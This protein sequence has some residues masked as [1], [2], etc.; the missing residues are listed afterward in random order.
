VTESPE[1]RVLGPLEVVLDGI[2]TRLAS[3]TQRT[4][5]A[6]L[7]AHPNEVVPTDR[8]AEVVWRG[9]PSDARRK[10]WFHVSKLRSTLRSAGAVLIT[11]PTGYML[12]IRPEQ[13]DAAQF[14]TLVRSA[15]S[16][17]SEDSAGAASTLRQA[18]VLWR[19]E[20]FED[21][22]H[23]DAVEPEVARL[24][25][26]RLTAVEDRLEADLALGRGSDVVPELEALVAEHPFREHFCAQLMIAL[27]RAGRQA[28]ALEAYRAARQKLVDELGLE[29]SEEL[30]KLE[31]RILA[32]DQTLAATL[33]EPRAS[34]V[35]AAQEERKLVTVLVAE[36]GL[37]GEIGEQRDPEDL[38]TF[39]SPYQA[40]VRS[41]IERYGGRV[42]TLVGNTVVA[43]FGS[44][45]A[46]DEDPERAVR[47]A[48]AVHQWVGE[49]DSTRRCRVA[50]ATGEALV[51][52]SVRA[53]EAEPTTV[54]DVVNAAIHLHGAAAAE[55]VFVG[56]QTFRASRH[57]IEYDE[58]EPLAEEA[59][60]PIRVWR[61]IRALAQPDI[62]LSQHQSP[63][64]GREHELAVLRERLAT[65]VAERSVQLVTILGVPGIGKSRLVAE[66]QRAAPAAGDTIKWRHGRSLPYED[67]VSF[68]ALGEVVKSESGI[69]ASDPTEAAKRKLDRAVERIVDDP[70]EAGRIATS[71]RALVGVGDA[72]AAVPRDE[73]FAAWRDFIEALAE[74]R[75]LVLVFEDLHW[76]DEGLLDFVDELVGRLRGVPLVVIATA[77]L[78]L[79]TRRPDWGGG[80]PASPTISLPPLSDGETSQLLGSLLD[81]ARAGTDAHDALL[82]R[83]GGNPFYAEQF[84]RM[85]R[86]GGG[87]D[88]LPETVHGIVDA[89]L[90][91]LP[92]DEKRLLRDAAVV[93]KIFWAGALG[94]IGG[95]PSERVADLLQRLERAEFVHRSRRSSIAGDTEYSFRHDLLREVAYGGL[96][97]A[98]RKERHRGTA[99]WIESLG[100]TDDLAELLAHHYSVALE[101]ARAAGEDVAAGAE[102]VLSALERAG[103]RAIRL[104]SN[105]RAVV[106]LSRAIELVAYLPEGDAR[107]RTEA[108]LQIEL[109]VALLA[110]RGHSAVEVEQAYARATELMMAIAPASEQLPIHFG[111]WM[112]HAQRGGFAR[113]TPL[114][115]RMAEL[116]ASAGDDSL[117]LQA[118]HARWG[119]SLLG[120]RIDDAIAAAGEGQAI[121]R[122]EVH[123]PLTFRYGNHDAGVCA[124]SHQAIALALRGDAAAAAERIHQAIKLSDVLG[125]AVSRAE[126][127]AYRPWVF[128]INGQVD[129]AAVAAERALALEGE[130]VHPVFFGIAHAMNAWALSRTGRHAEAIEELETALADQMRIANHINAVIIGAILAEAHIRAEM[131]HAARVLIDRLRPLAS[132]MQRCTFEPELLRVDAECR[133][134]AG[135][136]QE[137]RRL[138]RAAID[139]A[140]KHGSWALAIRA[141]VQL[142]RI[143]SAEP[144]RELDRLA[145]LSDRLPPQ[146]DTEYAREARLLLD[147]RQPAKTGASDWAD[148]G[149][150]SLR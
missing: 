132:S 111:L 18:L 88:D 97:R 122:P 117:R 19:G 34:D 13:L 85:L 94:A 11:R 75:A 61:A 99:E 79:L 81:R 9:E 43:L 73:T 42:E 133:R 27:Y 112:F 89:R 103:L 90:D 12:R 31:R 140:E 78:E 105:D 51:S 121:Y 66:L 76:A 2:A 145:E 47:A 126:P 33:A 143:S 91:R 38:R 71:L 130:V 57:A 26:L 128:Q 149:R 124:F 30:K 116:A 35:P 148:T 104:S 70:T 107:R 147:S 67:G 68:W 22:V 136:E 150:P 1:F 39:V 144:G 10:L 131:G 146:N 28:D 95:L 58:A 120:G 108:D 134:L 16:I 29:P 5:L 65:A 17:L 77:R 46:H 86:D 139:Q 53:L 118:L 50:V 15:R 52:V 37:L 3:P 125:H 106:H 45:V 48:L 93:G 55:G 115:E 32:H 102:R 8:I 14:E 123:H 74:E 44:P 80:K 110:L 82:A 41:E 101:Y 56:E 40:R 69:L 7:L 4:L 100:R 83:V 129:A 127:I 20:P 72:T 114:V 21:V 142:A 137:A 36:L 23:E 49:E 60:R 119:N 135:H 87:V 24:N 54:G 64:V 59:L 84:C 62:G 63:F 138:L 92:A 109:G 141:A 96:T 6:L 98:A 113:S 25:E